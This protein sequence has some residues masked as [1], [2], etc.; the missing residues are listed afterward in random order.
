MYKIHC[1]VWHLCLCVKCNDDRV[2]FQKS[3]WVKCLSCASTRSR[4]NYVISH[5]QA[6]TNWLCSAILNPFTR[7][8]PSGSSGPSHRAK[9]SSAPSCEGSFGSGDEVHRL[10]KTH[11]CPCDPV[12]LFLEEPGSNPGPFRD[13]SRAGCCF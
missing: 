13:L 2:C 8:N 1:H 6:E 7:L 5:F 11:P 3:P 9:C 12:S 4:C 10:N